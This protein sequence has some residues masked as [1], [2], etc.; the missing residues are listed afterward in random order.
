M[1][2]YA[3][4]PELPR[5]ISPAT[6]AVVA[7]LIV[8]LSLFVC[9]AG[10]LAQRQLHWDRLDVA[11]HLGA[12]GTLTVTETQA[13]VFT[14]DWN[15]GERKFNIRPR[16]QL[17]LAGVSR[18][19][20]RTW[21]PLREDSS[22]DDVDEY[23]MTDTHTLRWR[24]RAPEE[25]PFSST[26]I[27]YR[28]EYQLSGILLKEGEAYRLAHDFA[29]PDREGPI[30]HFELALTFD[31]EWQPTSAL[32][33]RYTA[34]PLAPG[35]SFVLEVPLRFSGEGQPAARD[36][37]RS[38]ETVVSVLLLF[39]VTVLGAVVWLIGEHRRG[40]FA[41]L[42]HQIDEAWVRE[43]ILKHPAEVV[44]AAWDENVGSAEVAA[45]IAR[46]VGDGQLTS[47]V[48]STTTDEATMA[49]QLKVPRSTLN[50]HE[51]AL[52]DLLFFN[53]RVETSTSAVRAH[54]RK[55][56]CNPA[57]AVR[58]GLE[59]AVDALIPPSPKGRR[60]SPLTMA[61]FTLGSVVILYQWFQGYPGAFPLVLPMIAVT[62]VGWVTG[63]KFRSY[64][65]WGYRAAAWCL[66]PS[67]VI[68]IATA[69]YV[70]FYAGTG[71]I[72]LA[73]LT[74]YAIVAIAIACILSCFHAMTSRRSAAAIAFRKKLTSGRAYFMQQLQHRAPALSDDWYPWLLG[75]ELGGQVDAWS[76]RAETTG[77]R[78]HSSAG[79]GAFGSSGSGGASWTGFGAGRSG[80]AGASASW[81]AAASGL[82]AAVPAPS[83]SGSG[84]GGSSG[85]SSSGGS[86]GGGGGGGW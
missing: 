8:C 72:E 37:T 55:S 18:D 84:S 41:P 86:S 27:R 14:G 57:E 52:V 30:E 80:G 74:A 15:G 64:L 33:S 45:L 76:T 68:L 36:L 3:H 19:V 7:G 83:S 12:D 10:A 67:L 35:R 58:P 23:A 20:A 34:G 63:L 38:T 1:T 44:A 48:T 4:R 39:G 51:R 9:P 81:Y 5:R 71:E 60:F 75:L 54:Y 46:M 49:L 56:G 17:L 61:L 32:Q 22:L 40:R 13:I 29:F 59:A 77:E 70:W 50:V 69:W 85:G 25:L 2:P 79:T 24:S 42:T 65:H 6:P 31:P 73:P 11:A 28:I 16:Q 53:N 21:Q 43:H 47:T 26:L 66:L 82:A 62:G 78:S